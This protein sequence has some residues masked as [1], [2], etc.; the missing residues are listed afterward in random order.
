M[1][2][3]NGRLRARCESFRDRLAELGLR[4]IILHRQTGDKQWLDERDMVERL[5]GRLQAH[6]MIDLNWK[7]HFLATI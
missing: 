6:N 3:T 2:G 5:G 7:I 4:L 1:P